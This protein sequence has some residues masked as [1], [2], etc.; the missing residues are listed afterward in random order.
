T[1]FAIILMKSRSERQKLVELEDQVMEWADTNRTEKAGSRR[2]FIML[3]YIKKELAKELSMHKESEISS[4]LEAMIEE[5]EV[6]IERV[7]RL[8]TNCQEFYMEFDK[9]VFR[10]QFSKLFWS[11]EER[12]TV[13]TP[14][15]SK[16]NSYNRAD[17]KILIMKKKC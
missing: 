13:R 9:E 5:V 10:K 4:R 11:T 6:K 8:K 15:P 3:N 17:M 7:E 12:A 2:T 14:P 16:S 1:S